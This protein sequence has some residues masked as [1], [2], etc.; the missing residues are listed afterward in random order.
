M[1]ASDDPAS[2]VESVHY[3]TDPGKGNKKLSLVDLTTKSGRPLDCRGGGLT[4]QHVHSNSLEYD[5]G[6]QP[7]A[8]LSLSQQEGPRQP[9]SGDENLIPT[10]SLSNVALQQSEALLR[11]NSEGDTVDNQSD[12]GHRRLDQAASQFGTDVCQRRGQEGNVERKKTVV[13]NAAYLGPRISGKSIGFNKPIVVDVE[14]PVWSSE[15]EDE[16]G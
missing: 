14:L 2:L 12:I 3:W 5:I 6:G 8:A 11:G 10:S 7:A 16:V 9:R 4:R 1:T 15:I 13:I